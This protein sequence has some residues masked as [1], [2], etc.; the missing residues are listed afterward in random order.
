MMMAS[1]K[2]K[3]DDDDDEREAR[4]G[5]KP[6]ACNAIRN[7][8]LPAHAVVVV[9]EAAVTATAASVRAAELLKWVLKQSFQRFVMST[10]SYF[11]S[12]IFFW[13]YFECQSETSFCSNK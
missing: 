2:E 9:G 13:T 7:A 11:F 4:F 10:K 5:V 3:R 8:R 1:S 12:V 6:T